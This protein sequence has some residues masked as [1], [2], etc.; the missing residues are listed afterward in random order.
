MHEGLSN[1][2]VSMDRFRR[3]LEN[4]I[5]GEVSFDPLTRGLYSTDASIYQID[6]VAV[7]IPED[8]AD[9]CA[10]VASA[11]EHS[12]SILP[13][14]GGTS[15]AGQAVAASLIIDF[16]KR[17]NQILEIHPEQ[18]WVRIQP[19][20]VR[21]ELNAAL[22]RYGLFFPIDPSTGNRANMGG[23]IGNDASGA[24]SILY[25]KT[26]DHVLETRVLLSDGNIVHFKDLSNDEYEQLAASSSREGII[27]RRFRE[28]VE[29]NRD[30]IELRYP[31][32]SRRVGGYNLDEYIRGNRWN[33]SKLMTGSE[34]TLGILLEA[35]LR[36]SPLPKRTVLCIVHFR[37][38]QEAI[39][40]V[41]P[42]LK[43]G[44]SA[45]EILDRTITSL[46]DKNPAL[47]RMADFMEDDP[48][49]LLIVEFCGNSVEELREKTQELIA[50]LK[51]RGVG[52]AY[53]ER[54]ERA[55]QARVWQ[56]RKDGLGIML[57]VPGN[58]K[59][60]AFIEDASVPLD[61]LPEY[62]AR[63]QEICARHQTQ[64]ALYAHASVGVIHV[65]PLLDLRQ[66]ED[67][68]RMKAI[69][70]E[71]FE[72]VHRLGG[73]LSAEHGD[74]LAR[75]PFMERFFGPRIY[76]AFKEIK[77]L[78]DPANLMNPGKIVDAEPLDSHLRYGENYR[79]QSRETIYHYRT[80]GGFAQEVELCT[81]IGACHKT[82]QGTMCPSYIA[83][84]DEEHS[85]RGRANAL[86][87]A[88]T[89]QL[90]PEAMTGGRL[91]R[92][93]E[94]C[95]SC[96]S[97][98]SECPS[99]VDMAKLKSEFL[100][101]Y[102]DRHGVSL[103]EKLIASSSDLAPLFSGWPAP[104]V[105]RIQNTRLFRKTLEWIAGFDSRRRLPEYAREPF[106]H[107]LAKR[108]ACPSKSSRKVV[109]FRDTYLNYHTPRIGIAAVELLE[110]CG[111]EVIPA[112][113]GCCQRPRISHGFLREA[114]RQ[115]E[116]TLRAL[117]AYIQQGLPVVVC[118][119]SCASALTDDLP[120]LMDDED[121]A[122]RIVENVT[123]IDVFLHR[124]I[125]A[126]N[127]TCGFTSP[128][129]NIFIHAHCHQEVLY[130]TEAMQ[131]LLAR[132]SG[133][134]VTVIDSGCCGMAGSFGHEIE[135]Y[136]LSMKIGEDRLF[137]Q[138]R[139]MPGGAALIACGFSCRHQ[140]ADGT[141][142]NALHWVETL[143]GNTTA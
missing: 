26:V 50:D 33:L 65:R 51:S 36:L 6:P 112:R 4:R 78:F 96:K 109:L 27:H 131:A 85:T 5:R 137:E 126:G 93:M 142:I 69:A 20:V 121:L 82:L 40:A 107:W 10:A 73:A 80:H 91:F 68:E 24:R 118:E 133:T 60:V 106:S 44:P 95:L 90:G 124:E 11:A 140:I 38:L 100:Q 12:V 110:S 92:A 47:S 125:L 48:E 98:K 7:V 23:M 32:K 55:E 66:R 72:L 83:T 79:P 52:Y 45:V 76:Q 129:R 88:M 115:G 105:N 63:V 49:A 34:G 59:P 84:R 127:L 70:E 120:D 123:M 86:R 43:H 1:S 13:R 143:R 42:I 74:G 117:D 58:R 114:K 128:F 56:V 89:G 113:A 87:L 62:V 19:G 136:E 64:T 134:T 139:R 71:T 61:A 8:E 35:K 18:G 54:F 101:S 135:H 22:A 30:E 103:R 3:D 138:I 111:Y 9:V 15:L 37:D 39:R 77:R 21:D 122:R 41:Q 17:L 99:N 119:P 104:L 31:K 130:G 97:C 28:I 14:G 29:A 75:S 67:I 57:N 46:I 132:A 102:H 141:G 16:S 94:L 81:G 2:S 53:P 25:G 108:S 116:K